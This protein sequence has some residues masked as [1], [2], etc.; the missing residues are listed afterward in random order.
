MFLFQ[1]IAFHETSISEAEK[2]WTEVPLGATWG[3]TIQR[4]TQPSSAELFMKTNIHTVSRR[5]IPLLTTTYH[6]PQSRQWTWYSELL[7]LSYYIHPLWLQRERGGWCFHFCKQ[8]L[9][10][11]QMVLFP[12]SML[13]SQLAAAWWCIQIP[14]HSVVLLELTWAEVINHWVFRKMYCT[15]IVMFIDCLAYLL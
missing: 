10:S 2:L 3:S 14:L 7:L 11:L 9:T 8:T 15:A 1:A 12:W 13:L 4:K 6:L 5:S